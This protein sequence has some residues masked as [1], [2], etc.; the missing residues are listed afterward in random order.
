MKKESHSSLTSPEVQVTGKSTQLENVLSFIKSLIT[1]L[2]IV[3]FIRGTIVEA[4]KIPSKSMEPT[5]LVGDHLLVSKFP[6]GFRLPFISE[7]LVQWAT[8]S[9]G[10]I[11]VFMRPDDPKSKE[12]ESKINV[13]KRVIGRPGDKVEVRNAKVYINNEPLDEPYTRWDE[14]GLKEGNF[15]PTVVPPGHIFLLGD[16]RD[17]SKDSRFWDDSP[18]LDIKR[19][20]GKALIIFWSWDS[21]T[22]IG[23]LI[24]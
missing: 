1:L 9:R 11:V 22:R 17:H 18:F 23:N 19:V 6:Y 3:I 7:S 12:D 16:N 20:K 2:V 24:R 15:G 5:L 10:D 21:P 13:I 4:Y 8:P 14:G